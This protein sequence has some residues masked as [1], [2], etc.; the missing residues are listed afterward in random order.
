MSKLPRNSQK[1]VFSTVLVTIL[2]VTFFIT[3]ISFIYAQSTQLNDNWQG[4]SANPPLG[5]PAGFIFNARGRS[6]AQEADI[7][8]SGDLNVGQAAQVNSLT[9]TSGNLVA[10]QDI[11]V[12][13]SVNVDES[14]CLSSDCI[15]NWVDLGNFLDLTGTTTTSPSESYWNYTGGNLINKTAG[16]EGTVRFSDAG[17]IRSQVNNG[18]FAT[19]SASGSVNGYSQLSWG[20]N[21][22]YRLRFY[23]DGAISQAEVMTLLANGNVGIGTAAPGGKLEIRTAADRSLLINSSAV[24]V[25]VDLKA[26]NP[27]NANNLRE[28]ELHGNTISLSTGATN[29]AAGTKRLTINESGNVGINTANPAQKLDVNGD[30]Q[31]NKRIIFPRKTTTGFPGVNYIQTISNEESPDRE[32]QD[33]AIMA[34]RNLYLLMNEQPYEQLAG[35]GDLIISR[36]SLGYADSNPYLVVKNGG[37]VGIGLR[38][39]STNSKLTINNP[40]GN[41]KTGLTITSQS[42]QNK[43]GV[44]STVVAGNQNMAGR[45]TVSGSYSAQ[46]KLGYS[47]YQVNLSY[48]VWGTGTSAGVYGEGI[49]GVVGYASNPYGSIG[50]YGLTTYHPEVNSQDGGSSYAVTAVAQGYGDVA[51]YADARGSNGIA[52]QGVGNSDFSCD[53]GL[54]PPGSSCPPNYG[55]NQSSWA[56]W[57][58]GGNGLYAERLWVGRSSGL[59]ARMI[60]DASS[61]GVNTDFAAAGVFANSAKA[62]YAFLGLEGAAGLFFGD[63]QIL[64]NIVGNNTITGNLKVNGNLT[65]SGSKSFVMDHPT[66]P[67]KEIHYVALEGGE[68]GTYVRGSAQLVNGEAV[69][70]LPE[71]FSLVTSE[72]GLTAQVTPTSDVAGLYVANKSPR[73]IVVREANGG[74]SNATFDYLINGVRKGFEN[75]PVIIDKESA[76]ND[77]APVVEEEIENIIAQAEAGNK[78]S[79]RYV[80]AENNSLLNKVLE[81][82]ALEEKLAQE[83]QESPL[84]EGE[85]SV[86]DGSDQPVQ[87]ETASKLNWWQKLINFFK[88]L[89][90]RS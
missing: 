14:I 90:K 40:T 54:Q 8:I 12:S 48:G 41:N 56:G 82:K 51:V 11:D 87:A 79:D 31:V 25:P 63:V 26:V 44:D 42:G 74:K 61:D 69:V 33:L 20:N 52:I 59:T 28:M 72:Q 77:L 70:N 62:K 88:G 37:S 32:N 81:N 45:F 22:N 27:Q 34:Q 6:G 35:V 78:E 64:G 30:I 68:S 24:S 38:N 10:N 39:P 47:P 50:I 5:N 67:T 60:S 66:D 21:N 75:K 19:L 13:G 85:E 17:I 15:T 83:T 49:N 43:I 71:H 65:V 29:V 53:P 86:T 80:P 9:V 73:Q 2:S 89:F 23:F 4:P 36:D 84:P 58:S 46:A 1:K 7:N 57:F 55:W 16:A 18:D 3:G 76:K